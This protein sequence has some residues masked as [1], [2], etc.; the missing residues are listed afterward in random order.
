MVNTFLCYKDFCKSAKALDKKRLGKQRVEALQI[1]NIIAA[2]HQ[3]SD[4]FKNPVPNDPYNCY[5]WIR[6]ISD[7]YKKKQKEN[8]DFFIINN[9]NNKPIKI[10]RFF[11]HPVILMWINHID[12]LKEYHD[13]HIEEWIYRGCNNTMKTF[14]IKGAKR[15]I[16]TYDDF[17]ILLH[18]SNLLHKEIDRKEPQ[19]YQNLED[20]KNLPKQLYFWPYTIKLKGNT[21]G[22]EDNVKRYKKALIKNNNNVLII[23]KQIPNLKF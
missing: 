1:I 17:F 18:R 19:W 10:Y 20:F 2:L 7:L 13:I 5:D 14:N 23:N 21:I 3:L 9:E 12:S 15:P 11:Y 16:W 22:Y 6:E 8:P 4:F